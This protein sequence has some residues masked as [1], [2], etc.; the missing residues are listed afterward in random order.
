MKATVTT[1]YDGQTYNPGEE[2]PDLGSIRCIKAQGNKRDYV[3]MS[4]DLDKLPTYDTL[5]SGSYALAADTSELFVYEESTKTW[6][7]QGADAT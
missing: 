2:I 3:F 1:I 4:K 7:Q 5:A 6:H